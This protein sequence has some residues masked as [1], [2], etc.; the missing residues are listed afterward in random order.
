[1]MID[2]IN[3]IKNFR[4]FKDFVWTQDLPDFKEKNLIYGWNGTGKTS[5]SDLLRSIEKKE[6]I[7]EGN[8]VFQIDGRSINI[9]DINK[10]EGVPQI[11]VFNKDFIDTNV[12]TKNGSIAP[13]FFLGEKN[14]EKQKEVEELNE[15]LKQKE[16]ICLEKNAIYKSTEKEFGDYQTKTAKTIKDLLS[17]SGGKNPYNNYD[18][19]SFEKKCDEIL[20]L[21]ESEK[22]AKILNDQSLNDQKKKI[23]SEPLKKIENLNIALPDIEHLSE[24]VKTLLERTVTASIIGDLQNKPELSEWVRAGL[25]IH[26]DRSQKRCLFCGQDL[27][28]GTIE[29]L[30]AHFNDSFNAFIIQIDDELKKMNTSI[31]QLNELE[32]P[33]CNE[34]YPHLKSRYEVKSNNFKEKIKEIKGYIQSLIDILNDKK[35]KPFQVVEWGFN[36][37]KVQIN[38][39]SDLNELI[40]IHN[41]ET[42]DFLA[43]LDNARVAIEESQ[44]AERLSEYEG[45]KKNAENA[46]SKFEEMKE[47]I[48]LKKEKIDTMTKDIVEHR[49]PAEELS[50]D[51]CAYLGCNDISIE[52][53]DNG[54]QIIRDDLPAKNLS[55]GEKTAIAFLYFL[56]SLKDKSF[57]MNDGIIVIDDPVSSLDSNA[58]YH[59]F[60]FLKEKTKDAK[61]LFVLTHNHT[62]F[63]QVK[64]WFIHLPK[65]RGKNEEKKPARFYMLVC[66]LENGKRVSTISKLDSLLHKYESEY[67]YLFSLVYNAAY[68]ES[69]N[70]LQQNYCL[71]N[72]ARRLLET[73]LAFRIPS[74]TG[75]LWQQMESIDF[76]VVKKVK[77]LRFLHTYSHTSQIDDTGYDPSILIETNHVLKDL[78]CLIQHEDEHHYT[79]M[80]ELIENTSIT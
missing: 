24:T 51:L 12:F 49:R 29:R 53:Q 41:K 14:I 21:S 67:H 74:K 11:R 48:R 19:R 61:Q 2:R 68:S 43:L 63:K 46:K 9:L 16:A 28:R 73:F 47:V 26:K 18:K 36:P 7:S 57:S 45:K 60:G 64:N 58:L 37:I 54:Y 80:I 69:E 42:D 34:L 77:I 75:H 10:S 33:N 3:R 70:N 23:A 72:I 8:I 76:D 62:F 22:K 27:P 17:S 39:V 20:N 52:I 55:E 44:I 6:P 56:K 50:S 79:Q 31:I 71:P 38:L 40:S 25:K 30:E 32:I 13:I 4:I 78:L 65:Q 15:Q 59:A 35:K 1:M 5:L 66:R